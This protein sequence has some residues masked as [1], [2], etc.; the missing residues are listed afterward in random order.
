MSSIEFLIRY[1]MRIIRR[2]HDPTQSLWNGDELWSRVCRLHTHGLQI[3]ID[4]VRAVCAN[5]EHLHKRLMNSLSGKI[6]VNVSLND[7]KKK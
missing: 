7:T 3:S 4:A 2:I 1:H 6:T 5:A